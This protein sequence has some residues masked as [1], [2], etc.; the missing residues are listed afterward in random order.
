MNKADRDPTERFLSLIA[1]LIAE[2]HVKGIAPST[3]KV[4]KKPAPKKRR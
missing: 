4:N 2:R 3:P 1:R